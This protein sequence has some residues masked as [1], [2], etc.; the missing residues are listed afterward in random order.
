M[1]I[2]WATGKK[3]FSRGEKKLLKKRER[4]GTTS[5][6]DLVISCSGHVDVT[7][8]HSCIS[9]TLIFLTQNML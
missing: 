6:F 1:L 3:H 5:W 8:T 9:I 4:G 2:N 7:F